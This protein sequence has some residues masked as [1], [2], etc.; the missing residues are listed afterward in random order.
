MTSRIKRYTDLRQWLR[1]TLKHALHHAV[2]AVLALLSTNGI[3][4]SAPESMKAFVANVGLSFEQAVAVFV[5]TLGT[6]VL[7]SV[8]EAT[9]PGRTEPPFEHP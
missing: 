6:A 4:A 9:A 1:A 3:E 7:R 2:G 5:V 8:H